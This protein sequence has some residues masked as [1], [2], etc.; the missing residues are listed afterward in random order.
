LDI[1]CREEEGERRF[2]SLFQQ[3]SSFSPELRED[4][5]KKNYCLL[6]SKKKKKN[7][8]EREYIICNV[9]CMVLYIEYI[10]KIF[11]I[12]KRMM[13]TALCMMMVTMLL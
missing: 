10:I 4:F 12:K 7:E 3:I 6:L 2:P 1:K 13:T 5:K 11:I 9:K 8:R